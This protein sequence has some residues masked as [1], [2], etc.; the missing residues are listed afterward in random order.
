MAAFV[1]EKIPAYEYIDL[2]DEFVIVKLEFY[3]S[4]EACKSA[5]TPPFNDSTLMLNI[6]IPYKSPFEG[7]W[8]PS[9]KLSLI[10]T[11][12]TVGS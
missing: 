7:F 8:K 3:L 1:R 11:L 9:F 5:P 6:L 12:K 2:K 10:I 4:N